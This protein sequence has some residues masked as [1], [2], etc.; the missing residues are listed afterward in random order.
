MIVIPV[1]LPEFPLL[2]QNSAVLLMAPL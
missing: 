2:M 1:K